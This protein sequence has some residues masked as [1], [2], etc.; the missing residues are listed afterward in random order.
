MQDIYKHG[1]VYPRSPNY[2]IPN[3]YKE[4]QEIYQKEK[5]LLEQDAHLL[6]EQRYLNRLKNS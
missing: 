2:Q 5:N 4:E 3:Q 1:H 6:E